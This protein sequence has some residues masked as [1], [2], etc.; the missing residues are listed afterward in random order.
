MREQEGVC[1]GWI[2]DEEAKTVLKVELWN[3]AKVIQ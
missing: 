3:E 1:G 2:S